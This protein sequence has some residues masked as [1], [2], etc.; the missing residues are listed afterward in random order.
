VQH[1][2]S[3]NML[4]QQHYDYYANGIN[5]GKLRRL[6]DD[7]NFTV[8][9][10]R[11]LYDPY[12]RL[13][14]VEY[15]PGFTLHSYSYDRWGNLTNNSGTA[16]TYQTGPNGA[17][18]NRLSSINGVSVSYDAAGN[19][20]TQGATAYSYDGANRL[21][22]A[23]SSAN[24]YGYD[25]ANRRIK[26]SNSGTV[27]YYVWSSL[28][29]Q[30]LLELND[31][32]GVRRACIYNEGEL[33]ALQ[34]TDGQFYWLTTDHLSSGRMLTNLGGGV[35]YTAQFDPFGQVVSEWSASGDLY[36]N[37]KKFAT[38]ERDLA[39]GLDYARARTYGSGLGRF[40]QS[41]PISQGCS[42]KR[43]HP[44]AGIKQDRPQ[45]LNRYS[46]VESDPLNATDPTG[47]SRSC[48]WGCYGFHAA[49]LGVVCV[50]AAIIAGVPGA[51]G[52]VVVCYAA[53]DVCID[54][55]G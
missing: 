10:R 31:A 43:P 47:L 53:L 8:N 27:S 15:A 26:A 1:L 25:A 6:A 3:G 4:W 54:G 40:L 20:M 42:K 7:A 12:N 39:T 19:L 50:T 9:P 46:Y 35:A 48:R 11:F 17:P 5:N 18:T 36:L 38:Y 28:L 2:G 14:T 16:L 23:G 51:V 44:L 49:C 13:Q 55:C 41:D 24:V 21:V 30:P 32:A 33:L 45:M 37:T 29:D 22:Q 34:S 52:C